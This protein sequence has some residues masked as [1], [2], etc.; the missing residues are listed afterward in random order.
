MFEGL[1]AVSIEYGEQPMSKRNDVIE[2]I[3]FRDATPDPVSKQR[4]QRSRPRQENLCLSKV[5]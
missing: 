5:P 4:A 1:V 2:I 3:K